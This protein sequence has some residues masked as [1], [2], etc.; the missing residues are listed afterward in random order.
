VGISTF[1]EEF[2]SR[3][4]DVLSLGGTAGI[5]AALEDGRLNSQSGFLDFTKTYWEGVLNGVTFGGADEYWQSRADRKSV[6]DSL[7]LGLLRFGEGVFAVD[8]YKVLTDP[9]SNGWDKAAAFSAMVAKYASLGAGGKA[10][11]ERITART[12]PGTEPST[13]DTSRPSAARGRVDLA[14][15]AHPTSGVR[16]NERGFPEFDSLYD[17]TIPERL[18]GPSI[19]D[20]TQ[21]RQATR[22]LRE[23]LRAN[24]A[25]RE[26]FTPEQLAAIERGEPRLPDLT[27]HHVEDGTTLQLVGRLT[28][29][30]TGHSGGRQATGG[31][32]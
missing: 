4:F 14:G 16:F 25:L 23:Y 6:V 9:N 17:T 1:V 18:R 2:G 20:E 5:K 8:Q 15:Q 28:H 29:R 27:W 26:N 24:P 21:F 30:Q 10:L 32:P 3:A 19:A 22:D 11:Q 13:L 7:S 31:R 12:P